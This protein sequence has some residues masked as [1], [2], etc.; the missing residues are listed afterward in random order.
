MYPPEYEDFSGEASRLDVWVFDHV[1]ALFEKAAVDPE[2]DAK[3]RQKKIV[4]FLH[5]LGLDTNGHGFRPTSKEYL[6]NIK[7]VDRGVEEMVQ[8]IENFYG[9]DGKTSYVF[10]ADHGMNNRGGH[11]DGHPDNTRTPIVAWGAGVRKPIRS[12]LGHDDF[13]APWGLG[14]VQRDDIRQADIA[15]LM[16]HLVGIDLPVNSVGELPLSY[17]DA[18]EMTKAEAAFSNARQILEQYQVKHGKDSRQTVENTKDSLCHTLDEKE[19]LELFFRPFSQ[20]SGSNNPILLVSEIQSLIDDHQYTLA[21]QKS[22]ELMSHCLEGL[23]Y[24][25]TYDWFFLRSVVTA[26]YVG[27]CVFCLEFVIRSFVLRDVSRT[28]LSVKSRLTVSSGYASVMLIILTH[29]VLD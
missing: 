4:F 23:R 19:Q 14:D 17:L 20:L 24:F 10:T 12:S 9:N 29:V 26:G 22:R 6:D 16:A 11:G 13:S 27:W 18:D 25:Q 28:N 2:L 21:E 5:L 3:L 1:K 7:L 15:P 8:L